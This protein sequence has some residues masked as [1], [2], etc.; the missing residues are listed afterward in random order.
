M[1]VHPND[2]DHHFNIVTRMEK[3]LP[4]LDSAVAALFKDLDERG[5]LE[6]VLVVVCGEMGRTPRINSGKAKKAPGRDHWGSAMF[7]LLGGGGVK[8][9]QIVGATTRRGEE[10][11]DRP[12][13]PEDIHQTIYQVLGI[14]PQMSFLDSVGRPTPILDHGQ[15]IHEL[16]S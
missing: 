13:V 5:L 4:R 12:V 3:S 8:G 2:W 9:G 16:L 14:D 10:V 6:Q 1:T 15:V 7:C 11:K